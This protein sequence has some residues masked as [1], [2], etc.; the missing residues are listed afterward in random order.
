MRRTISAA[1]IG[2]ICAPWEQISNSGN[3]ATRVGYV[4]TNGVNWTDTTQV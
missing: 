2:S 3:V 4:S 1:S